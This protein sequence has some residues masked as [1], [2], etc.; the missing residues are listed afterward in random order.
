ML[1][2]MRRTVS[3]GLLLLSSAASAGPLDSP[4]LGGSTTTVGEYPN[5]VGLEVGGGLCTGTLIDKE[6][7]LTA[8]HCVQGISLGSIR[9][10][11]G[12]VNMFSSPGVTRTA[13]MAI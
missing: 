7:V 1:R 9:V 13:V 12:T 4:I 10:H 11:F 2:R 6:W 3:L 5:V 8:A